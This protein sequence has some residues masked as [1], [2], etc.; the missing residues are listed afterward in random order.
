MIA[1]RGGRTMEYVLKSERN[2]ENPTVFLIR[3]LNVRQRAELIDMA[4]SGAEGAKLRGAPIGSIALLTVK[5]G[6]AGW[7]NLP[8]EEGREVQPEFAGDRLSDESVDQVGQAIFELSEAVTK[9]NELD[10][11]EEGNSGSSLESP[12][13]GASATTS[14]GPSPFESSVTLAAGGQSPPAPPSAPSA[15][16]GVM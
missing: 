16:G 11:D 9:F 14:G 1:S 10:E 5:L 3:S 6:I 15:G 4:F 2:A 8:D 12:A 7:R 13:A